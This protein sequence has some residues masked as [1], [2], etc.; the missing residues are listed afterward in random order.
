MSDELTC[1]VSGADFTRAVLAVERSAA[2]DDSRPVLAGIL[3]DLDA[4]QMT[5]T[6]DRVTI[7]M[8]LVAADGFRLS[9]AAIE[10][11]CENYAFGKGQILV[12]HDPL[13]SFA[14][15]ARKAQAITISPASGGMWCFRNE[16]TKDAAI[17]PA[18]EGTY[19][20]WRQIAEANKGPAMLPIATYQARYLADAAATA[21]P[22]TLLSIQREEGKTSA[23]GVMVICD[24]NR[25]EIARH[26]IMPMLSYSEEAVSS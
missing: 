23:P 10:A 2:K 5:V 15:K 3:I 6:A 8:T 13:V 21:P 22:D 24:E 9:F 14:R 25:N 4:D 1:T 20:D 18:I 7:R 26:I 19:P 12:R 17:I 11:G 16:K